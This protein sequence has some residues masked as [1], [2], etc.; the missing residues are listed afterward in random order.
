MNALLWSDRKFAFGAPSGMLPFYL[1]RLDGTIARL[2]HKTINVSEYILSLKLNGKWSVKENIG[3]L[4]EGNLLSGKRMEE[5]KQGSEV[6][7]PA[8]PQLQGNY[9]DQS[10]REVVEHFA[11]SRKLYI[12]RFEL[13]SDVDVTKSSL[14]PRF[15]VSMT[16]VD[17]AL[18]NADHDD[19][20]LVR[21]NEIISALM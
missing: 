4:S 21:I 17:L 9:N 1:E 15:Q 14:H 8:P 2:H 18:F 20:H 6:L 3:H 5:I 19:H 13:L 16:P 10:I 11:M 7:S 12:K